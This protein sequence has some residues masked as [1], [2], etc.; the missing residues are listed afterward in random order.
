MRT[1]VTLPLVGSVSV[2][3]LVRLEHRASVTSTMDV[4]HELAQQGAPAGTAVVADRQQSG[5]GRAGKP[6]RSE[7]GT[8]LWLTLLERPGDPRALEVLSLRVG[9]EL[10]R[11]L[12]SLVDG[13]IALKWPNDLYLGGR[14]LSG[15]LVEARWREGR[16]EWVAIGVGINLPSGAGE[17]TPGGLVPGTV[18]VGVTRDDLL[19]AVVPALRRAAAA[20]GQLGRREIE[21][22]SS[23]DWALGRRVVAPGAGVVTGLGENGGLLVRGASGVVTS[24]QSGSLVFAEDGAD[25][26]RN[27]P[28]F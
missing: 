2:P 20:R 15:I 21:E 5:R 13:E 26:L 28:P 27:R 22:W 23:R 18:R 1:P 10:A 11:A 12:T 16:P 14:K 4:A 3:G 8:G 9:L 24:Y 6:W 25:G 19:Q 7:G 17:L